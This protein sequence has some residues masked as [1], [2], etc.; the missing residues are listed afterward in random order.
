M[1]VVY[2]VSPVSAFL[3][4]PLIRTRFFAMPNLIAGRKIVPELIQSDFTPKA[5]EAEVSRLIHSPEAR[6][7]MR[8][9]L[10]EVSSR[11]GRG[12]AI[13]RAANAFATML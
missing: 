4:R 12:G 9:N 3:A 6:A 13:E 2:R 8:G 1:V 7:D 11:L 10:A 5:V